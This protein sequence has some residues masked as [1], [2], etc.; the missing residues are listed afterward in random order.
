MDIIY[1]CNYMHYQGLPANNYA[2]FAHLPVLG[3]KVKK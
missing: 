1:N 2:C 3:H